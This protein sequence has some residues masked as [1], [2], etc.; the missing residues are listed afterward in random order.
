MNLYRYVS[1]DPVD[2]RD[3]SGLTTYECQVPL[4][5]LKPYQNSILDHTYLCATL[6]H[7]SPIC[8][9][10]NPSGSPLGFTPGLN[11]PNDKYDPTI[12]RPQNP[13][14]DC[15]DSCVASAVLDPSRPTYNL[16]LYNCHD[17]DQE[18]LENCSQLCINN[19]ASYELPVPPL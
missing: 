19:N 12:C 13:D 4:D 5:S 6:G 18:I 9:S 8:G 16:A 7:S 11:D 2:F 17:W 3:P 10:F 15:L 1:S 14:N